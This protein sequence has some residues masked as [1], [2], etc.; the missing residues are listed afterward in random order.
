MSK[1]DVQGQQFS[2]WHFDNGFYGR[3]RFQRDVSAHC[4]VR[5]VT[6]TFKLRI[7]GSGQT[8]LVIHLLPGNEFP[9]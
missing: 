4:H 6:Y 5:D 3:S 1:A 2:F 8:H 9:G 7:A